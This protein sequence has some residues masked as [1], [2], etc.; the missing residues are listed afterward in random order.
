[1]IKDLYKALGLRATASQDEI[2]KSYRRLA[3]EYHPDRNGASDAH[4][5]FVEIGEAY[6]I[7]SDPTKRR[8]YDA[9]RSQA[10]VTSPVRQ[11]REQTEGDFSAWS[12]AA[13][14]KYS[15]YASMTFE[16]FAATLKHVVKETA[17]HTFNFYS[18]AT[19]LLMAGA[20][21]FFLVD[22][23]GRAMAEGFGGGYIIGIAVDLLM[24]FGGLLLVKDA[25]GDY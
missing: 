7:L 14:Q 16:S 9:L 25:V 3:M 23:V 10:P 12:E 4:A 20:G 19:G 2:K 5:R 6:E 18:F 13:R 8:H 24:G 1:M 17:R 15:R 22:H 11:S 21:F